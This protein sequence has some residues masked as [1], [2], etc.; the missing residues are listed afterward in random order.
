MHT[1]LIQHIRALV[2]LAEA[3]EDLIIAAFQQKRL[4]RRQFFV[5]EG[6]PCR[7]LGFVTKGV[8][9]SYF[10]SEKGQEHIIQFAIEGWWLNDNES[11]LF[12]TP[13]QFNIEALEDTTLLQID[14]PALEALYRDVPQLERFFRIL[15]Q[16]SFIML[17][18]RVIATISQTAEQRYLEFADRYPEIVHRVPQYQL[19]AYLGMTAEFLSKIRH[20]IAVKRS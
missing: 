12:N 6:D 10:T 9:R 14:R 8:L 11:F 7:Y 4:K 20:G 2:P 3:E 16:R 15:Y 13:S 17:Q 19:A 1:L 18:K 5:Q